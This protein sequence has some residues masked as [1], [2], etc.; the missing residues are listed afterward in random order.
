MVAHTNIAPSAAR[1]RFRFI[2][3]LAALIAVALFAVWTLAGVIP[4]SNRTLREP[5]RFTKDGGFQ[6]SIFEDL[7]FVESMFGPTFEQFLTC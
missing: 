1:D 5:L 2:K 4:Q 7:H 6:I 3:M